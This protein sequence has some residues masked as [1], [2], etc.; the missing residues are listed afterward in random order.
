MARFLYRSRI[1]LAAA[2]ASTISIAV[3]APAQAEPAD[4]TSAIASVEPAVVRID[5]TI[6]YQQAIGSGT[7]VVIDPNG[8]VLTNFH[9]VGGADTVTAMVAGRPYPADLIGYSRSKD[10][11]VLQLRGAGGLPAA[12]IGDSSALAT[13]EPVVALG[14]ARGSGSPL[15]NE[16]GTVTGFGRTISAKDELTGSFEQMT[17]LIEF[18][19]P[20]RPGDSGGPL[21]NSAGQVVGVTTAATVNF[22]MGPGGAGFAIPIKDALGIAAQIRAGARSDGIHIG[23]PTLLGVGVSTADQEESVPGVIIR[24]VI[25]GGPAEAAGLLDGDVLVSIDGEQV[26]SATKLT[27]VLD[28]HYAGDVV[29]LVWVDRAGRQL[30]GKATLVSGP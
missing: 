27:D 2:M 15:T 18:A 30:N 1:V 29:D 28:R 5:T 13:G 7:G 22:R 17:G 25:R 26:G 6:N 4:L 11:A 3:P 16:A 14:N 12:P 20:V 10:I 24:E 21:V 19:A 8:A 9:V 23:P